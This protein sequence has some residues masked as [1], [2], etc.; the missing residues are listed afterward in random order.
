M[1]TI[2][3]AVLGVFLILCVWVAVDQLAR[4]QLGERRHGCH[5]DP[6]HHRHGGVGCVGCQVLDQCPPNG[7][8]HEEGQ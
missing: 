8:S 6:M 7:A 2:L 1:T 5:G 3:T 4:K